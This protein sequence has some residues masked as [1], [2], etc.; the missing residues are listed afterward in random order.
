MAGKAKKAVAR[1]SVER[2]EF[3]WKGFIDVKL[4][5]EDKGNLAAWDI[6]DSAVWDGIAQ[7]CEGGIKIA[8][9]YNAGNQTFTC[10]GTGQ[11]P[12]GAN[13]GYCI[14]AYARDPYTAAR[15]WLFKVST[16]VTP[17]W[18]DY[19]GRDADDVG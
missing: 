1:G 17:V 15:T 5:D 9:S 12:S 19:E 6:D 3:S 18:S 14:T 7:Y 2:Q 8:I 11:P 13:S 10:A 4:S 16:L